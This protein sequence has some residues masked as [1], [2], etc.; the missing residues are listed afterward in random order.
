[1]L[2]RGAIPRAVPD[3]TASRPASAFLRGDAWLRDGVAPVAALACGLV[4][5]LALFFIL[6]SWERRTAQVA[7]ETAAAQRMEL[8]HET[9]SSSLEG[10]HALGAFFQAEP[11]PDRAHFSRFVRDILARRPEL[12]ALSW[13][14]RVAAEE[15]PAYEARARSDGFPE[16]RFT[17][18][19]PAT[20]RIVPAATRA[21]HYPVYFIEPL[22]RNAAALGYDLTPRLSTLAAARDSG[23]ATSTPPI[24][25]VQEPDNLPGFIV[26][27]PLYETGSA[28]ATP[29]TAAERV[30][31]LRG[32]VA[33]VF[34]VS[35]LVDPSLAHLPGLRVSLHD[36]TADQP[37]AYDPPPADEAF[38]SRDLAPVSRSLPYA[39][40]E[41]RVTFTPTTAF[42]AGPGHWQSWLVLAGGL[43]LTALLTAYLAAGARA[44]REAT[45]ANAA[46]QA[47][48]HERKRA[49]ESAATANHAKSDFLAGLSHEIRTPLNSIL[50]YAQI[51][52]RDPDL[53]RRQRDAVAALSASGRHLLG[54][55][56]SI[57]D[58]SKIEAGRAEARRDI[59]DL[60][61]LVGELAEMFK[62]RCA[63]KR[64]RLRVLLPDTLPPAVVGDEGLLRQVLINLLGNAVK[65]TPRGE[66]VI[67]LSPASDGDKLAAAIDPDLWRFDVIDTGIGL[68]ADERAG[69]FTPFHQ[70]AAGRRHGGTGLGLALARRQIELM[71]G[72]IDVLPEP[73]GGTRFFFTLRLPA[74]S[75]ALAPVLDTLPRFAPEVRVRALVVDDNRDNRAILARLLAEIGCQV[76]SAGSAAETRAIVAA[77]PPDILFVDVRLEDERTGPELVAELR[78][79]GF[80]LTTPV[81]YHTAT[82]L[83]ASEREALRADGG[84]LLAKPF[85]VED[86]CA[87]LQRVP[88]VRF[89]DT[90]EPAEPPAL[91]L[92]AVRLPAELA[93]RLSVAAELHSTTVLK[94]CL[95]ELRQLGGP[96]VP[97]ADHLRQLLRGYDLVSISRIL[98]GLA[99]AAPETASPDPIRS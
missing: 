18:I 38:P 25:L 70:T 22:G 35:K 77:E 21:V 50:G 23:R 73:E 2:P 26:Y 85:R 66:I 20:G 12:H 32:F 46:L 54:L 34:R 91:D 49:E 17:D 27:L 65:F 8:L 67:R 74:S 78:A 99:I 28:S 83:D 47:E 37:I 55:L 31:R 76:A 59:F 1:M 90:P 56:N 72:R 61:A 93:D 62:P 5:S 42:A 3:D 14:P 15:R 33:A 39:G 30:A 4:C 89:E 60:R 29:R 69:L 58:L 82:L 80:P 44:R 19:E 63:E 84:D 53:P 88:G 45:R 95:D 6:R 98:A 24:L 36:A 96:A 43:T 97:L 57:L 9:L 86:L 48:V 13:T 41:W 92:A 79:A 40:R 87:C 75:A 51:L 68:A 94:A 71:G 10:L 16:F 64:I 81:V 7:V 11:S 52:E